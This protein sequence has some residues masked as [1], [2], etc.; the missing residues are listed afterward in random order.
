MFQDPKLRGMVTLGSQDTLEEKTVTVCCAADFVNIT[1]INFCATRRD[2]AQIW[3]EELMQ[4]AYNL[5]QLNGPTN[6]FLLK[7]YTKLSLMVD[8]TDKIPIKK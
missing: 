3:T 8:K 1:F 7:A 6:M 4:L 5:T 2:I